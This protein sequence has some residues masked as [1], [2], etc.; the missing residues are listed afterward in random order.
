MKQTKT[1]KEITVNAA[2]EAPIEASD[3]IVEI[4]PLL[5]EYFVGDFLFDK[6]GVLYRLL[7]GQSFRIIAQKV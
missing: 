7:N 3:L 2:H 4:E 5:R 1:V 6:R